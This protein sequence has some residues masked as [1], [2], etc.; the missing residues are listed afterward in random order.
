MAAQDTYGSWVVPAAALKDVDEITARDY[1]VECFLEGQRAT[2]ARMKSTLGLPT[3]EKHL[4]RSAV[5]SVRLAFQKTGGDYDVPTK[6]SIRRA[7]DALAYTALAAGTPTVVVS[8]HR[9]Q[10][11]RMLSRLDG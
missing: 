7:V 9:E 3:D 1:I 4:R 10:I 8:K 6:A 5:G 11:E 2:F